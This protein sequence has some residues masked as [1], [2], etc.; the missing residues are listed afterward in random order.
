M[1]AMYNGI[2]NYMYDKYSIVHRLQKFL[3]YYSK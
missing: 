2:Q 3:E 1:V